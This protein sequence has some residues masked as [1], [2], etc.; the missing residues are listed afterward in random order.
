[1]LMTELFARIIEP[2]IY[3]REYK[4]N[5]ARLHFTTNILTKALGVEYKVPIKF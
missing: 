5:Q 4:I 3:Y 1:M 2:Y